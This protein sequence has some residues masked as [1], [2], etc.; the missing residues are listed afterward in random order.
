MHFLFE[1]PFYVNYRISLYE[2]ISERETESFKNMSNYKKLAYLCEHFPR[3]LSKYICH[4][5]S[6]RQLYMYTY[7]IVIHF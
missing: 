5:F 4:A 1:C 7:F 2:V 6:K 3:Q